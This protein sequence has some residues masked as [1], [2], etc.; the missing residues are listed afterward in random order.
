MK[1]IYVTIFLGDLI[2]N[3][4]M[5]EFY[6]EMSFYTNAGPYKDY[7][8]SLPN[9]IN[10]LRDLVCDQHI[11]KM[12]VFRT[13]KKEDVFKNF[14]WYNCLYDALNTA[15][16]MT[17]EIFR[18]D[19]KG[20]YE[21]RP[22]DKR[23]VVTCRYISILFASILKSKGI[24]CRCRS[25]FAPYLYEDYNVDHWI[26][27]YWDETQKRWIAIDAQVQDT[28]RTHDKNV[29]LYDI[30]TEFEYPAELWLKARKGELK[31]LDKYLKYT[32]YKGMDI[33]AHVL[34]LDFNALMNIE[35]PYRYTP[36][37]VYRENFDKLTKEDYLE[38]DNLAE[39]MLDPDKNFE[40]LKSLWESSNE[41]FRTLCGPYYNPYIKYRQ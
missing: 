7:F 3:D 38:L 4:R 39:L 32:T 19:E 36:E 31:D 28:T 33:L 14:V 29:N 13:L 6:K 5:K 9:D 2:M 11:H 12:R 17:S 21:N 27:E 37:F 22:I 30:K 18:L 23:I 15:T 40:K 1:A 34:F 26:N 24:P 16:A 41:K 35:L 25:G 8:V 10:K 20:F